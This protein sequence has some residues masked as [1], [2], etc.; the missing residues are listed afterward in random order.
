MENVRWTRL[1]SRFLFC[2]QVDRLQVVPGACTVTATGFFINAIREHTH[3]RSASNLTMWG[4]YQ[5]IYYIVFSIIKLKVDVTVTA[6]ANNATMIDP[7]AGF[8]GI[9]E[10]FTV[11]MLDADE[12]PMT[13]PHWRA[14]L[15]SDQVVST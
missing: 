9:R 15:A 8:L 14:A 12:L 4:G 13:T 6:S 1:T 3:I 11:D 2:V 5:G 7:L 10:C